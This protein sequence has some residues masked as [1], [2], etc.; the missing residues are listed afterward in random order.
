MQAVNEQVT[1][2]SRK[3]HD[4][5]EAKTQKRK[6]TKEPNELIRG[7]EEQLWQNEGRKTQGGKLINKRELS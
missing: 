6:I 7:K 2:E 1:E 3:N 4:K 5:P